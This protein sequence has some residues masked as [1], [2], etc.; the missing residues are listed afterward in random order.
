MA[1]QIY[2]YIYKIFPPILPFYFD[3]G[4]EGQ[5]RTFQHFDDDFIFLLPFEEA[6][7]Q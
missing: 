4:R 2:T 3:G 7:I 6:M 1:L 5:R